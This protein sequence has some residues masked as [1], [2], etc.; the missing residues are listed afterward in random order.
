MV[1]GNSGWKSIYLLLLPQ[2]LFCCQSLISWSP[3][4][5]RSDTVFAYL[6]DDPLKKYLPHV[7]LR[8]DYSM[9]LPPL[10]YHLFDIRCLEIAPKGKPDNQN[11]QDFR[12]L[13]GTGSPWVGIL[14]SS[15]SPTPEILC[16]DSLSESSEIIS[17]RLVSA[18]YLVT[19][20][21][22]W[23]ELCLK[24]CVLNVAHFRR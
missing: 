20:F 23:L 9:C 16:S 4:C 11:Y 10:H 14:L 17:H 13:R 3:L 21:C 8:R 1:Y 5:G 24:R 18:L 12:T 6:P 15:A 19:A 22:H 2:P 7:S